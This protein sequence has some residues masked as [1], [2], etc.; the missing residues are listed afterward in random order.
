MV[1]LI[2]LVILWPKLA[3]N[4]IATVV[5][6]ILS[7]LGLN[8]LIVFLAGVLLNG[9]FLFYAS[10]G[11]LVTSFTG[12]PA[13]VQLTRGGSVSKATATTN[14]SALG[15][16]ITAKRPTVL[17]ALP[18]GT[19][20][21]SQLTFTVHGPVSGITSSVIV[22]LPPG[23]R[24]PSQASTDYPV[25]ETFQGY[26]GQPAQWLKTLHLDQA[27]A[28]QVAQKSM[29]SALIVSPNTEIPGGVDTECVNG[30]GRDPKVETW[31]TTDVP[32]WI[33]KHFRVGLDRSSW[34]TIGL[35]AGGWCAAMATMKHPGTYSTAIVMA[36]Y[37]KP[38][39]GHHYHPFTSNSRE[40][41]VY[42]MIGLARKDPPPV[43][44]WLE[45]SH[46]D[47]D[48]YPSTAAFLKN[49]RSPMAVSATVLH[50][51]GHR[52]GVWVA[53]LPDSLRWLGTN[54]PGFRPIR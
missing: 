24:D 54:I 42:D 16:T 22:S 27:I 23:Y 37:F 17:P 29:R 50:N 48:S 18:G 34:A 20:G 28:T 7:V 46:A 41:V 53:L 39:F 8:V 9:Q 10:W 1:L 2:G 21:P 36:G 35:S 4:R 13:Q 19:N 3:P 38:W 26:P 6:R 30:P 44:I 40:G 11:D 45:T 15:R 52:M 25:L 49:V 51:A 5:A 43:A 47:R 33:V 32:N 31:L 14:R 12:S